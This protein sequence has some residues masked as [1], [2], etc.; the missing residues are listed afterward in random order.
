VPTNETAFQ[1]EIE[2][3]KIKKVEASFASVAFQND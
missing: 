2:N 3:Q 1:T